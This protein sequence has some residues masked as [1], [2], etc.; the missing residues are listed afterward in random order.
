MNLQIYKY[1]SLN[2]SKSE[3]E[4]V[5]SDLLPKLLN[6]KTAKWGPVYNTARERSM[7]WCLPWR[8][9][10]WRP[11]SAA[12]CLSCGPSRQYWPRILCGSAEESSRCAHTLHPAGISHENAFLPDNVYSIYTK[13][14]FQNTDTLYVSKQCKVLVIL[15]QKQTF[16]FCQK[17]WH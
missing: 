1:I 7:V 16:F 4:E 12:C 6:N 15:V 13:I 2:T 8:V 10:S 17:T 5:H 11:R 9:P 14:H 3:C